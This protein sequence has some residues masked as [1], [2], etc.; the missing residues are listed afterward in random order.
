M[1]PGS[2]P[3]PWERPNGDCGECALSAGDWRRDVT[4]GVPVLVFVTRPW[5]E[6]LRDLLER[7]GGPAG[8]AIADLEGESLFAEGGGAARQ[9]AGGPG[10]GGRGR[11][12]VCARAGGAKAASEGVERDTVA[13]VATLQARIARLET[14]GALYR[15]G[16]RM[17][18]DLGLCR[19]GS[20]TGALVALVTAPANQKVL[21]KALTIANETGSA[22]NLQV[23]KRS[24]NADTFVPLIP[25]RSIVGGS[26]DVCPE[27]INQGLMATGALQAS[28]AG[29]S[30]SLAYVLI[31]ANA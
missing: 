5:Q 15:V 22:V 21:V 9:P 12:T 31:P 4:G 19:K 7:V 18:D 14:R 20:L 17:A 25:G 10:G 30:W 13:L 27:V 24:T 26:T 6:F 1:A 23:E 2:A 28:G 16:E 3:R 11:G 8:S 29:L